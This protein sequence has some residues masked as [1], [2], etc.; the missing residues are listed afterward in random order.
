MSPKWMARW[1]ETAAHYAGWSKDPS[2]QV[3]AVAVG[4]ANA[5]LSQG[6][7]GLPRGVEDRPERME[8]AVKYL[9]TAHAEENLVTHAARTVLAGSTVFV[10]HICCATCAR[11]LV[12]SGVAKVVCGDGQTNMPAEQFEIARTMFREAGIELVEQASD[13]ASVARPTQGT[14]GQRTCAPSPVKDRD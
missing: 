6:Y 3:G 5:Q 13:T 12:N 1:L 4:I 14:C 2:T 10:T 11:M 8:R 9:W 7:N